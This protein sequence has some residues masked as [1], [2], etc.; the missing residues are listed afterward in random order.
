MRTQ[1]KVG[2]AAGITCDAHVYCADLPIPK[3]AP[4]KEPEKEVVVKPSDTSPTTFGYTYS[5]LQKM[6]SITVQIMPEK[7]GMVF[8]Y[9]EYVVESK[10]RYNPSCISGES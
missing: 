10:V 3:L 1:R 2:R 7:K 5:D 4:L 8:K 6:D 9:Q